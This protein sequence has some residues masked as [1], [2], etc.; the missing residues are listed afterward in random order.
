MFRN[1]DTQ[2]HF[3]VRRAERAGLCA[4]VGVV[5]GGPRRARPTEPRDSSP[6]SL[7]SRRSS[8]STVLG[9]DR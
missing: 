7:V 6:W 4:G 1:S 9:N 5:P 3:Q 2:R 8:T